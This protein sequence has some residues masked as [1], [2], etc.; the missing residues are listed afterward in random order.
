MAEWYFAY[1]S[2]LWIEQMVARIG[3]LG[4]GDDRP[5]I[6][7]LPN[8]RLVFNVQGADGQV[9]ANVESPGDRVI[10]VLY[11]CGPNTLKK[12]DDYERGYDRCGVVVTDE[13]GI[14]VAAVAKIA[15]ADRIANGKQPSAT[16]PQKIVRGASQHGLPEGY[17]RALAAIDVTQ[18]TYGNADS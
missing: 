17:I 5:R 2:N 18:D 11:R 1:G 13:R 8:R 14:A 10:G 7:R 6:A 9:Y 12:L 4:Q 3:P 16:Y 15:K